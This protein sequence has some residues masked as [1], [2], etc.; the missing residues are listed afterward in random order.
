MIKILKLLRSFRTGQ[1]A[2]FLVTESCI[3]FGEKNNLVEKEEENNS[4]V[5]VFET[6]TCLS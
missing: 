4:V 1:L 5:S 2:A 3:K 6:Y